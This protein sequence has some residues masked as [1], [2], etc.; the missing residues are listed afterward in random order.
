VTASGT[1]GS[2]SS[3]LCKGVSVMRSSF[4]GEFD[5]RPV[6]PTKFAN[7]SQGFALSRLPSCLGRHRTIVCETDIWRTFRFAG[8]ST[9]SLSATDAP[10]MIVVRG[11]ESSYGDEQATLRALFHSLAPALAGRMADDFGQQNSGVIDP[12]LHRS[13]RTAA[14]VGCFLIGEPRGAHE[15]KSFP[16]VD[17]QFG[18]GAKK[19][20]ELQS[21]GLHGS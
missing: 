12:A 2:G 11:D 18:K 7:V 16:L 10:V 4:S 15:D 17:R 13:H 14:D 21:V 3:L 8:G 5:V 1:I 20:V 9:T 19:L 6:V